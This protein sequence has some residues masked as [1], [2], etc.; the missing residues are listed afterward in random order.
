MDKI[1]GNSDVLSRNNGNNLLFD[2]S[3]RTA[4]VVNR[5]FRA[6]TR[7]THVGDSDPRREESTS[8]KL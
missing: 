2:N 7:S 6:N 3:A 8:R 1:R 4:Q 5:A